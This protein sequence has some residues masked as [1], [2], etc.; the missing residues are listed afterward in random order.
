[1]KNLSHAL[2]SLFLAGNALAGNNQPDTLTQDQ[3]FPKNCF[4]SAQK[5]IEDMLEG[6]APLDYEKAVF[7]TENAYW[8][9]SLDHD[10]YQATLNF[11]TENIRQLAE[12]NRGDRETVY[13]AT[14]LETAE[15]QKANYSMLLYN[16]AIYTYFTEGSIT[17][18]NGQAYFHRPFSYSFEDPMATSN[19]ENSQVTNLLNPE[20]NSG[21][22]Y[23]MTTLF[24]LFAHRLKTD[25][26]IATAPYHIYIQHKDNKGITY[27]VEL[28]SRAFP[29]TGSMQAFTYSTL[30][31]IKSGIALRSL[32][33][34]QCVAMCLVYLAKG[35]E[36]K[37]KAKDD[38]FLMSC[39]KAALHHDQL[40]LNAMLVKTE[41]MEERLV[42]TGKTTPELRASNAFKEY[43]KQITDL[44][45]LG[46]QE[47]PLEMKNL[48]V[49]MTRKESGVIPIK[50]NTPNAFESIG[51]SRRYATLSWGMLQEVHENKSMERYGRTMFDTKKQRI[52]EFVK[53]E[54]LYNDYDFDPATF[55]WNIDP[56]AHKFPW[57][58]PYAAMDNSPIVKNDPSG[59]S[60]E[61]AI[62]KQG[63]TI[64]ITSNLIF[65]G[66]SA[67]MTVAKVRA[68]K[69]QRAWNSAQGTV[70]IDGIDYKVQFQV[71]PQVR[72]DDDALRAEIAANKDYKNNYIRLEKGTDLWDPTTSYVDQNSTTPGD[73]GNSGYWST[74]QLIENQTTEAHEFGHLLGL[75]HPNEMRGCQCE[76][77][78]IMMTQLSYNLVDRKYTYK[79][80][81][82]HLVVD[83]TKRKVTK[84]DISRLGLDKLTFDKDGKAT[85]GTQTNTYHAK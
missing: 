54:T 78:T 24:K 74:T 35:F 45:K 28:A 53:G 47:M 73:Q 52:T 40:N 22:C 49:S 43:E 44:Y 69:I 41:V 2:L 10:K 39:A 63:K 61:V 48:I 11:H 1:M 16:W 70:K 55:A 83:V 3:D 46:Y 23:A 50:D 19:W 77:P 59:Q 79:N 13:K 26:T 85:V 4:Y 5:Q 68:E 56:L 30:E 18:Q 67:N 33:D 27:N 25:A 72:K 66:G 8:G 75:E 14:W 36:N 84:S 42:K 32:D 21:N 29:G 80:S 9:N 57:Q 65:Y 71:I 64:T 62:D 7:L 31:A 51:E 15:Q 6:R 38:E 34:K 17:V 81:D 37:F 20:K 82:G 58:S 76:D 12:A 60:G